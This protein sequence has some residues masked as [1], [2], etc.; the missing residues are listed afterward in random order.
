ME[1]T[2]QP[3][4]V[5]WG[6]RLYMTY[7]NERKR[8]ET[9]TECCRAFPSC[10][11]SATTNET[12]Q[13]IQRERGPDGRMTMTIGWQKQPDCRGAYGAL[14][15]NRPFYQPRSSMRLARSSIH[16]PLVELWTS[17]MEG[18]CML[19]GS[20]GSGKLGEWGS[21]DDHRILL[22]S[23]RRWG[24]GTGGRWVVDRGT[25]ASAC[26]SRCCEKR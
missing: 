20:W 22:E 16:R 15:S 4:L 7:S 23:G 14:V 8:E 19:V 2:E 18:N 9:K 11:N 25:E 17:G 5:A 1:R 26:E 13:G 21:T 12:R 3:C 6:S 10:R 24:M